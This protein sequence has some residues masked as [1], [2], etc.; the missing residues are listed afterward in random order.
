MTETTNEGVAGQIAENLR[1][2][3]DAAQRLLTALTPAG[4]SR[5][6]ADGSESNEPVGAIADYQYIS[7]LQHFAGTQ[8]NDLSTA[9]QSMMNLMFMR[10]EAAYE[11]ITNFWME[12]FRVLSGMSGLT[13]DKGDHRFDDPVW[14]ST[15][16]YKQWMQ[17]YLS[18][19]NSLE[20][21]V[22]ALPVDHNEAER[23]RFTF[24]LLTEAL[25]P[26][27]WPSNPVALRRYM[28]TGGASA[29]RGLNNI[30]DDIVNNG[31][32]PSMVKRSALRV[33][34]DMGNTPGK[35]VY[36]T[37]VF[38]LIQYVPTTPDVYARPYL[39]V[40]PQINKFY[41]Y[42][43][44]PKKSLIRFA[45]DSGLKEGVRRHRQKQIGPAEYR[46]LPRGARNGSR[47]ELLRRR[48]PLPLP[49]SAEGS[50]TYG[51]RGRAPG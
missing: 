3:Q 16:L 38:E 12:Q 46:A 45:L 37:E 14:T 19:R 33:G 6:A 49:K 13:P 51:Y 28:E 40:P 7:N 25:A 21:W 36:R 10:P 22:N 24:S 47:R 17:T 15:P 23:L 27:N 9:A 43:L 4:S 48:G 2:Y 41:F 18:V 44:S 42:D 35:V 8:L 26:S 31:G 34:K 1:I 32:M 39:M 29:L 11:K 50:S 5:K 20:E 30:V